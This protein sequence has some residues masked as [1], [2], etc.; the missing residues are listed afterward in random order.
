MG[1]EVDR[2]ETGEGLEANFPSQ[3]NCPERPHQH[4][5][6]ECHS[7]SITI[8]SLRYRRTWGHQAYVAYCMS[9]HS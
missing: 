7:K 2:G 8:P 3:L 1:Q 5:P 9:Q 6:T 4:E